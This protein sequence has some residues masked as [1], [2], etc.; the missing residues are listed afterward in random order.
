MPSPSPSK[1]CGSGGR[2]RKFLY[3]MSLQSK[4]GGGGGMQTVGYDGSQLLRYEVIGEV[5]D[6]REVEEV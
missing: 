1:R 2:T 6:T 4:S 3:G 5:D